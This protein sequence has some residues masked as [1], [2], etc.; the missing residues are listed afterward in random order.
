MA[1][2]ESI[3]RRKAEAEL[4]RAIRIV[5]E[6][7]NSFNGQIG[8]LRERI[9][10]ASD[11]LQRSVEERS[12]M[13]SKL[14]HS[15]HRIDQLTSQLRDVE[16]SR[17]DLERQK[18]QDVRLE[19]IKSD[20]EN[21]IRT[22]RRQLEQARESEKVLN[23]TVHRVESRGDQSRREIME[24][25]SELRAL[26]AEN[27]LLQSKLNGTVKGLQ[28]KNIANTRTTV[29]KQQQHSNIG[30]SAPSYTPI[31]IPVIN[32]P[33]GAANNVPL[34]IADE[35]PIVRRGKRLSNVTE[36]ANPSVKE[37]ETDN[38]DTLDISVT[39]DSVVKSPLKKTKVNE[40]SQTN[41]NNLLDGVGKKKIKLP[42]R[43]S[44]KITITAGN[45]INLVPS[46][47]SASQDIPRST[48]KSNGMDP[49]VMD[50]IMSSF[51]IKIPT[52]KK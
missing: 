5:R 32:V 37:S 43:G 14:Q 29:Q 48:P 30:T 19:R 42:E 10:Y 45:P 36:S 2:N 1:F 22:M 41:L 49:T 4:S 15:Q 31:N 17:A 11:E 8:S 35:S 28:T 18:S 40:N 25:E 51:T 26:R 52:I 44:N 7:E 50:S 27:G 24:L 39:A 33:S 38:A 34:E 3:G 6:T 9:S 16:I 20:L 13:Q 21:E 23:E 12:I 46:T 47:P